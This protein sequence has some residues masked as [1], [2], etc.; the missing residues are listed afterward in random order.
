M[1]DGILTIVNK[2]EEFRFKTLIEAISHVIFTVD[3]RGRFTY[4]SQ[5]CT[6]ILGVPPDALLG[7][8]ITSAVVPDDRERLCRK[9]Y[10]VMAGESY[11]SDYR[12][13]D[14][15]GHIR[16]VRV[17]SRTF[18]AKDGKK[19]IIGI[20]NGIAPRENTDPAFLQGEAKFRKLLEY[21]KDGIVL[22][23]ESGILT[24]WSPAME[25]ISGIPRH[26]AV[27]RP[28][29]E[30]Q[31]DVMPTEK[32]ITVARDAIRESFEGLLA[33]GTA[34]WLDRTAENEIE[35]PDMTRRIVESYQYLIPTGNGNMIAAIV[36]DVTDRKR[37]DLAVQEANR[38]LNLM[39]T[40]TRHD[41]NNQL[42]ILT[43]YIS[44]LEQGSGARGTDEIFRVIRASSARIGRILQFTKE[45][46][47][48]GVKTPVWQ[49]L[50]RTIGAAR[51][52]IET[53]PVKVT[54]DPLCGEIEIFADPLL[55]RVF[56]N[57]I[58]NSL[59]HG[60]SVTEIR[61]SCRSREE[62]L[63]IVYEDNGIGIPETI[64]PVLF[65][66]GRG[67]NTGY[68]MFLIREILSITGFAIAETGK[69]GSGVHF[70]IRVPW[71]AFRN[72]A[73][74][75]ISRNPCGITDN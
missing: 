15:E 20:L 36:R 12:V 65:D 45:Y 62:S 54:L 70:E 69:T 24:E 73:N 47:D 6:E 64:R 23:D 2:D 60:Q 42:T 10:D 4:L 43:G 41:I 74:K 38:K 18:A 21:S 55:S 59:R 3:E 9:F 68:G 8:K 1:D 48:V 11:P 58:D 29:W 14:T 75:C 61:I 52:T 53:G 35:R 66:R 7:K 50:A 34:P 44:L 46:Q 27:G 22:T 16:H 25:K 63:L 13:V 71:E 72:R 31:Y 67:G 57:L 26:D 32:K 37:G 56:Y 19:G 40:I 17:A 33:T 49:D 30:V 5:Q 51:S 28:F 39:S